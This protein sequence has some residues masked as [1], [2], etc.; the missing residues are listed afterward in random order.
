MKPF[1]EQRAKLEDRIWKVS[2]FSR[3]MYEDFL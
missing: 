3:D 1:E 2:Q